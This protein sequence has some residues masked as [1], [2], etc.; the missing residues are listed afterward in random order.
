MHMNF[1]KV[2]KSGKVTQLQA[3][4][5]FDQ[6]PPVSQDLIL[7]TWKGYEFPSSHPMDGS[8]TSRGWYGK[9]FTDMNNV[10]PLLFNDPNDNEVFAAHPIKLQNFFTDASAENAYMVDFRERT[11]TLVASARIRMVEFRNTVSVAM[12]Y[13]DL[14]I[15]DHFRL[16]DDNTLLGAMDQRS[17]SL[18]YFFVLRRAD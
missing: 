7:G 11:E 6:L 1:D 17:D 14:A 12:I 9:R 8:L 18:N 3:L 13:D 15:I 10:D 16:V 2:L 5:L 4:E